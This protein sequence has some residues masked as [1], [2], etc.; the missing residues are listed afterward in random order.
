M[1]IV[2]LVKL[3]GSVIISAG[4]QKV[5]KEVVKAAIGQVPCAKG[6]KILV[7]VGTFAITAAIAH[8]ADEQFNE[9]VDGVVGIVKSTK[10]A[11]NKV[12]QEQEKTKAIEGAIENGEVE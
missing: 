12:R 11:I 6:V 4:T 8:G 2:P 5:V 9:V 7:T 1:M 3:A 10:E